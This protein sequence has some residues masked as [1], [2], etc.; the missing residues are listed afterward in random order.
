MKFGSKLKVLS[1]TLC[2]LMIV[3]AFSLTVSAAP[4]MTINTVTQADVDGT[5]LVQVT[6]P[7][8]CSEVAQVTLLAVKAAPEAT[9]APTADETNIVYIDQMA[10]PAGD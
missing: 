7:F 3:S 10:A 6:V 1:L 8:T 4:T 2:A 9:T 5:T